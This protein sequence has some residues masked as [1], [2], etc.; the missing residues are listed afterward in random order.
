[1]DLAYK[2]V[3]TSG[4]RPDHRGSSEPRQV[5]IDG[6]RVLGPG[7]S[8]VLRELPGGVAD[9]AT[10]PDAPMGT[11]SVEEVDLATGEPVVVVAAEEAP[12]EEASQ[13]PAEEEQDLLSIEDV[14][15]QQEEDDEDLSEP[16][17]NKRGKRSKRS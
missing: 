4:R 8:L 12:V 2:V 11:L 10:P 3:N 9:I 5:W 6:R 15:V 7:Q 17:D 1:M 13:V 16:E 14:P